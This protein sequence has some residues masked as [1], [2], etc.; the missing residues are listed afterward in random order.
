MR[1]AFGG[2]EGT[3]WRLI[4]SLAAALPL[5]YWA[6]QVA[7]AQAAGVS[8]TGGSAADTVTLS[9][10][11]LHAI[12]VSAVDLREFPIE[13]HTVGTIDFNEDR[14]TQVYAPYQGRIVDARPKLGDEVR[15]GQV[16]FTLQSA[17]FISAQSS[18]IAAAAAF[19]QATS[20]L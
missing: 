20:T 17:D 8:A 12:V 7:P 18:L 19:D 11:Q 13:K 14:T 3:P 15:K 16:L 4:A 10:S 5:A 6:T 9:D 1:S 2:A